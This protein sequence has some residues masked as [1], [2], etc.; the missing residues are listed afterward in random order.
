MKEAKAVEARQRG[1]YCYITLCHTVPCYTVPYHAVPYHRMPFQ[2]SH[3]SFLNPPG[4]GAV[5]HR[6]QQI[7][8][9]F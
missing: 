6:I 4:D 3:N 2:I 7:M 1:G 9:N 8:H 5:D